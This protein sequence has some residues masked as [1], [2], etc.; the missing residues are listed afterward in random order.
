MPTP[1]PLDLKTSRTLQCGGRIRFD[2]VRARRC[3]PVV[4]HKKE[5]SILNIKR[6]A[7][8]LRWGGYLEETPIEVHQFFFRRFVSIYRALTRKSQ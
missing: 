5:A 2:A 4:A 7:L 8:L 6:T 1:Q 3:Y